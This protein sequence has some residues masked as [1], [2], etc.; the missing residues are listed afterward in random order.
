M[1]HAHFPKKP[2]SPSVDFNCPENCPERCPERCPEE[3]C[4]EGVSG[5]LVVERRWLVFSALTVL[6]YC[7][8]ENCPDC[9][10]PLYRGARTGQ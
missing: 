9:P 8:E 1:E 2:D 6:I 5:Q 4:P 7:P 10:A 3:N